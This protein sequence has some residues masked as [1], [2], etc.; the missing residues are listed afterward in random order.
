MDGRGR[1]LDNIFIERLWR[2]L[3]HENV[4]LM[5]YADGREARAGIGR[6]IG[7]YNGRRPHQALGYKTPMAVWRSG[8][9]C[10]HVDNAD[11]LPTG[12]QQQQQERAMAA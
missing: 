7:F 5:A 11:A 1:Y 10:G 9:G 6:W 3:K 4:Y 12:P 2:S 8:A